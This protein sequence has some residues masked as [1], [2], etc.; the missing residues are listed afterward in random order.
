VTEAQALVRLRKAHQNYVC[1]CG[2]RFENVPFRARLTPKWIYLPVE[3]RV[4]PDDGR[5]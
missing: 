1:R 3:D 5:T 4:I 2:Y